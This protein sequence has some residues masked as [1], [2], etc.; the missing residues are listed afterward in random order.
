MIFLWNYWLVAFFIKFLQLQSILGLVE[1]QNT[2][3]SQDK[4]SL[5]NLSKCKKYLF[6]LLHWKPQNFNSTTSLIIF[7]IIPTRCW[8]YIE[9]KQCPL[10]RQVYQVSFYFLPGFCKQKEKTFLGQKIFMYNLQVIK[11]KWRE[12]EHQFHN[13]ISVIMKKKNITKKNTKAFQR[14]NVI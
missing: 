14:F 12:Y 5:E 8:M 9:K 11:S 13:F 7:I 6:S 3:T 1:L 10:Q 2:S 4:T